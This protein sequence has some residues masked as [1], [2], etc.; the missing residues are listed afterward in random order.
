MLF[1]FF[2]SDLHWSSK[3][4]NPPSI[5][6]KVHFTLKK[7]P[8]NLLIPQTY[9]TFALANQGYLGR[10]ARQRSAK[11]CT[12]VRIRQVPHKREAYHTIRLSSFLCSPR[13]ILVT[14]K[15]TPN[16]GHLLF[17]SSSQI[18]YLPI[19]QFNR[20]TSPCPSR[21]AWRRVPP[22][23]SQIPRTGSVHIPR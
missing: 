14:Q 6:L 12:A 23:H 10:V 11:P 7:R 9:A 15:E 4:T 19:L 8:I 3:Q 5:R 17:L 16:S 1:L 2:F 18:C 22:R 21:A 20:H 13:V